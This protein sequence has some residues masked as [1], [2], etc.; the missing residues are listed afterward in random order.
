[1]SSQ[2]CNCWRFIFHNQ[3]KTLFNLQI[4]QN[5][6]LCNNC[7]YFSIRILS[8]DLTEQFSNCEKYFL[9]VNYAQHY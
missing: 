8:K 1:M 2:K 5:L 4:N 9:N 6:K 7:K 3:K